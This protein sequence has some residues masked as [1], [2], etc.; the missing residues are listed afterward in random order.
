[1]R[2]YYAILARRF[3]SILGLLTNADIFKKLSYDAYLKQ[4]R[5]SGVVVG[6]NSQILNC[7]FSS[8]HKGDY[9][10]FSFSSRRISNVVHS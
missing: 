5:M 7:K 1:V 4:L 2:K 6:D 8:S 3:Y 9:Q 10:C